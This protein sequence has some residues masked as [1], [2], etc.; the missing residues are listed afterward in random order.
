M[1][2]PRP[3]APL[4]DL[5]TAEPRPLTTVAL[6]ITH[7]G[8]GHYAYCAAASEGI[9]SG[10]VTAATPDAATFD[11]VIEV[12]DRVPEPT[13]LRFA[14]RLPTRSPVLLNRVEI[15][16][17]LPDVMIDYPRSGDAELMRAAKSRLHRDVQTTAEDRAVTGSVTVAT[18]GS[19]RG[20]VTGWGWLA[21][22]G[23]HRLL[24]FRHRRTQIGGAVVLVAELRAI[25]DAA[26]RL[27]CADLM[28]LSDSKQAVD[29]VGRWL[30]GDFVLPTGYTTTRSSGKAGL[31]QAQ[32]RIHARRQSFSI[33]WLPGH[34]GHPL[35]EGADGLARLASRYALHDSGLSRDEYVRRADGLARAFA[36]QFVEGSQWSCSSNAEGPT[37]W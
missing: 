19:V 17:I 18:D 28:V 6:A 35:N 7:A 29:M 16:T 21:S 9:W 10:T 14:I 30:A 12:R 8:G 13:R 26:H 3:C 15:E 32:Q 2:T 27:R 36:S 24:G 34:T 22:S 20:P 1:T 37:N 31:V 23:E 5:R 11:A 25:A 4:S 33:E